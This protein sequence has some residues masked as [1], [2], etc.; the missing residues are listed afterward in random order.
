MINRL[1]E[2]HVFI[3]HSHGR[4]SSQRKASYCRL[5]EDLLYFRRSFMQC[6]CILNIG[7][8]DEKKGNVLDFFKTVLIH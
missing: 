3:K 4:W 2:G 5:D 6:G 7:K 1:K 8:Q